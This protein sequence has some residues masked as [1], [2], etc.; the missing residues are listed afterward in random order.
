[1]LDYSQSPE[2]I[3]NQY[4]TLFRENKSQKVIVTSILPVSGCTKEIDNK[5]L[6]VNKRLAKIAQ[7]EGAVYVDMDKV[8]RKDKY[9]NREM[10]KTN[11]QAIRSKHPN[12]KGC[13]H[14]VLSLASKMEEH[15]GTSLK[16]LNKQVFR[17]TR[18][19]K[20]QS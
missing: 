17:K 19:K 16:K 14:F 18:L 3:L 12:E 10:Y 20:Q 6:E 1:M 15:L 8:F 5:V 7:E 13:E 11:E 9:I 4:R 2:A